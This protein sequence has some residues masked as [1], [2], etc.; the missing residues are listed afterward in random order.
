MAGGRELGQH[1]LGEV[2]RD[3]EADAHRAAALRHDRGVD[4]D[5][6]AAR[7]DE[8]PAAVARIDRRI[9]LDEVVVRALTDHAP[10]GADDAGRDGLLETVRVADRHDGFAHLEPRRVAEGND[11]EPLGVDLQ[12]HQIRPGIATQ[13]RGG[14]LAAVGQRH[15]DVLGA[16]NDVV[17]GDDESVRV[18]HEARAE[19][20]LGVAA[21]VAVDARRADVDDGG[22]ERA[23]QRHPR[24]RRRDGRLGDQRPVGPQRGAPRESRPEHDRDRRQRD[25]QPRRRSIP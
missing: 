7:V 9:G 22:L 19:A 6:L 17:V 16:V 4:A 12:E 2:D 24:R 18:D 21:Q 8:W 15:P 3:R 23:R 25:E 14:Q 20:L 5:R 11:G 13:H 1:R 10:L